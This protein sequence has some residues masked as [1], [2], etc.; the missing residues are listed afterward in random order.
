MTQSVAGGLPKFRLVTPYSARMDLEPLDWMGAFDPSAD[1]EILVAARHR[2]ADAARAGDWST[3]LK[4]LRDRGEPAL[5]LHASQWR[6]GSSK[7]FTPL[8]QAAWHGASDSV[9]SSLLELGALRTLRD[10]RG[11]TAQDVAVEKKHSHS[12][13]EL[14]APPPSPFGG[15]VAHFDRLLVELIDGRLR[16]FGAGDRYLGPESTLRYPSLGIIH[17]VPSLALWFHV[18][19]MAGGFLI[20]LRQGY[21]ESTSWSKMVGGSGQLHLVTREGVVLADDG[22]V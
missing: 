3:T 19:I 8:H 2:L 6:P 15:R 9:V 4:L 20:R 14:L 13:V 10:A 5:S 18:P 21:I 1:S 17:E 22:F 7:W 11:R 12:L 16:E